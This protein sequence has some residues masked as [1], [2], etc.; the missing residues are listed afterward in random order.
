M[1]DGTMGLDKGMAQ[2][3]IQGYFGIN[4]GKPEERDGEYDGYKTYSYYDAVVTICGIDF[5][6]IEISTNSWGAVYHIS[7]INNM[8]SGDTIHEYVLAMTDEVN[9]IFGD[10]T[11]DYPLTDENS[12][13]EFYDH[14][15]DPN[16][17]VSVGGY[18]TPTYNSLWFSLD[19][20]DLD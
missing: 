13:I 7:F 12:T 1:M 15:L 5:N 16:I 19:D 20:Y 9:S 8:E 6:V 2:G 11:M 17:V 18:Y 4:L 14:D 10:P 3:V